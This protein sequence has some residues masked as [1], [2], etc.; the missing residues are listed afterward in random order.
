MLINQECTM[1]RMMKWTIPMMCLLTIH[2]KD[3]DVIKKLDAGLKAELEQRH[4]STRNFPDVLPTFL[5]D[6]RLREI[7]TSLFPFH[8]LEEI[9]EKR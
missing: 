2:C 7:E 1:K 5:E 8:E 3:P 4:E 9:G 6:S